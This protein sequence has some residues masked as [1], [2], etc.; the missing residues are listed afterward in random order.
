MSPPVPPPTDR[1]LAAH[2]DNADAT[3]G[4][5]AAP[6]RPRRAVAGVGIRCPPTGRARLVSDRSDPS[7]R[8]AVGLRRPGAL[9]GPG[10]VELWPATSD[11]WR[12]P[13]GAQRRLAR[14]THH[15]AHRPIRR[16]R[17]GCSAG[18]TSSPPCRARPTARWPTHA[19]GHW[20][21]RP[22][23]RHPRRSGCGRA[24]G[25]TAWSTPSPVRAAPAAVRDRPRGET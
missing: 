20:A 10:R 19:G 22:H 25:S 18:A 14:R 12:R 17:A 15:R 9:V 13:D 1:A 16:R 7:A 3:F 24:A 8:P 11:R 4:G 6:V 5:A 21:S 23:R 2:V